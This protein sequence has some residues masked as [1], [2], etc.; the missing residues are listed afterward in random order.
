MTGRYIRQKCDGMRDPTMTHVEDISVFDVGHYLFDGD[1]VSA[2]TKIDELGNELRFVHLIDS[3]CTVEYIK[4]Q[5]PGT[6]TLHDMRRWDAENFYQNGWTS[7]GRPVSETM[8]MEEA[9]LVYE[10]AK[11]L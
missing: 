4:T 5:M 10:R 7:D 11:E 9:R 3:I 8:T 2:I 1:G 6:P